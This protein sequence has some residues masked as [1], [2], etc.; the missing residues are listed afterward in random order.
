MKDV[1]LRRCYRR[2]EVWIPGMGIV[3]RDIEGDTP[4]RGSLKTLAGISDVSA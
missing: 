1:G 3:F 2:Y 4:I